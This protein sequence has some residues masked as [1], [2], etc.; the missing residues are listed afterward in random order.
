MH[1][2]RKFVRSTRAV[3]ILGI[4]CFLPAAA[5]AGTITG[6]V[7]ATPAKYLEESVV[8]IKEAKAPVAKSTV[9]M[10]QKGMKFLPHVLA[11]TAGD[12]V[13]F[14]NHDGVDHNVFSPDNDGYNLGMVKP[15][16]KA[17]HTFDKPGV[18]SQL[19]SVHPEMLGYIF[20]GQNPY[21]A[22]VDA[23]GN[24]KIDHVPAG[25]YQLAVWNSKLKA[26]EQSVTV[27]EGKPVEANF[28]VKR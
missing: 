28:S 15:S 6:K 23:K 8:Y 21:H 7:D 22:V 16:A 20:V 24:F 12:S 17:P 13:E 14:L 1:A 2:D 9:S 19:C 11:I 18:Y 10:D 25:T 5:V 4:A 27:V 26:P 3:S